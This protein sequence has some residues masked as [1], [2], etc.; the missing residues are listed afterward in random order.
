MERVKFLKKNHKI[1]IQITANTL[2]MGIMENHE[3]N[4]NLEKSENPRIYGQNNFFFGT[5]PFIPWAVLAMWLHLELLKKYRKIELTTH[6]EQKFTIG[7]YGVKFDMFGIVG[8][9]VKYVFH[10][11][12]RKN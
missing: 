3:Q 12:K 4:I 1:H 9:L 10:L 7:L 2:K 11:S 6:F 5:L 8:K